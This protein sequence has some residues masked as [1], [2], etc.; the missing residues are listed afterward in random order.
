MADMKA[1]MAIDSVVAFLGICGIC[2]TLGLLVIITWINGFLP[3]PG[4]LDIVSVVVFGCFAFRT[5]V[6]KIPTGSAAYALVALFVLQIFMQALGF[7][8]FLL[9]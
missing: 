8:L 5:F 2:V 6:Q 3:V 4:W 9:Y 7:A 1:P